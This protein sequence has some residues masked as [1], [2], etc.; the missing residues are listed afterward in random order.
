[1]NLVFDVILVLLLAFGL[2]HGLRKGLVRILFRTFK[3]VV[4]LIVAF[5]CAKPFAG[6]F[7][8]QIT[9][10]VKSMLSRIITENAG[11]ASGAEITQRVPT[12]L[13]RLAGLF[14]VDLT[15]YGEQALEG[16]GNYADAFAE[17]AANPIGNAVSVVI[18]FVALYFLMRLALWPAGALANLVFHA[19]VLKQVNVALG[20]IVSLFF[21]AIFAWIL[22]EIGIFLISLFPDVAFLSGFSVEKT[23]ICK[24][25][26]EGTLLKWLLSF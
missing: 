9:A 24:F 17:L 6:L 14:D 15:A 13:R 16:G 18:A 8:G 12:I 7:E 22:C 5:T 11:A 2:I 26:H 21:Y 19:P 10:S 23:F 3:K 4:A 1:M 25:L 20:G